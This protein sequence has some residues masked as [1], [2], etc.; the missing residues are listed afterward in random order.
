MSGLH[1]R[2]TA[3]ELLE[4][5]REF[6]EGDVLGCVEGRVQFHTRVAINALAIVQRELEHPEM[7]TRHRERLVAL[8][9]G[10]DEA[11]AAAIRRGELD[12]RLEEVRS[13]LAESVA[14]KLVVA[15]PSYTADARK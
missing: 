15:N 9:Y 10:S 11:L 4:A 13:V 7:A 6:L 8:G 5:V 14:D 12:G 2:P 3:A 1:D